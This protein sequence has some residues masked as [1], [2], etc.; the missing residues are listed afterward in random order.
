M[1]NGAGLVGQNNL[2]AQEILTEWKLMAFI[3]PPD[4]DYI[5]RSIRNNT[6]E[7]IKE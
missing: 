1:H 5:M 6:S 4:P 7:L 2:S 3:G